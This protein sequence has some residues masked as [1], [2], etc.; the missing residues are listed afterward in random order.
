MGIVA[1]GA[2]HDSLLESV[3]LVKLEFRKYI[4]MAGITAFCRADLGLFRMNSVAGSAVHVGFPMRAEHVSGVGM[5]VAG[6]TF[7]R[8]II[9]HI[10]RFESKYVRPSSFVQVSFRASMAGCAGVLLDGD[11]RFSH[12]CIHNLI[13][14]VGTR[15]QVCILNYRFGAG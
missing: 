3:S 5:C 15:F 6:Q 7:A 12:E 13:V 2:V 8:F 14:A 10:R 11:M 9:R 4:L 1:G